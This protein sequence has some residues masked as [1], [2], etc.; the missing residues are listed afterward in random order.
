M[1]RS[2]RDHDLDD[3]RQPVT[4]PLIP[5]CRTE[6][7]RSSQSGGGQSSEGQSSLPTPVDSRPQP[8]R[9]GSQRMPYREP[10][11]DRAYALRDSEIRTLA[12]IGV[13]RAVTLDDLT[14]YRYGG[15]RDQTRR[16]LENLDRQG[17][18]RRRTTYPEHTVY[19]TLSREGHRFIER[20]RPSDMNR[21]QVLYHGFVKPREAKHDAALYRLYQHET[22]RIRAE[23]G[24]VRR[25]VLDF[26]LKK[27]INRKLSKLNSLPQADQG[28]RKQ[29]IAQGHGLT[30]VNG[31][32]PVPDVRLEFETRDQEQTKVDLELA[33]GDY[34]RDSLAAKAKAGF[35]MYALPED[36]ARLRPA[37]SD[38][39]IM[40]EIFSL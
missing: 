24:K 8:G 1:A 7:E 25:V 36:A 10:E 35:A 30:V 32:I 14:R 11:R 9:S 21:R 3:Q 29:E 40:Q 2:G 37:M 39:E 22:E 16:D 20:N 27:S 4:R 34:H 19:L 12:E 18:I 5:N 6:E 15:N 38:P 28:Q 17:L 26:E 23:G 13:F 33:T 31:K